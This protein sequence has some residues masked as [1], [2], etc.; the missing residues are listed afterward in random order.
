VA[1]VFITDERWSA[2]VMRFLLLTALF[3]HLVF[4]PFVTAAG[5]WL[6]TICLLS[7]CCLTV[8][9]GQLEYRY[10]HAFLGIIAL[11]FVASLIIVIYKL[12]MKR[13]KKYTQYEPL[14]TSEEL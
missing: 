8:L 3:L 14:V 1:Y 6:E 7:L 10:S 2:T 11:P 5:Q 9:N 12:W 4:S 13:R